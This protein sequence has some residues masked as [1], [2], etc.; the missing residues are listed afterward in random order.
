MQFPKSHPKQVKTNKTSPNNISM[1][2][3]QDTN[4]ISTFLK[5]ALT[6]FK[7]FNQHSLDKTVLSQWNDVKRFAVHNNWFTE[8]VT[9]ENKLGFIKWVKAEN[10]N[11]EFAHAFGVTSMADLLEQPLRELSARISD[12]T[13]PHAS[14]AY[15][16]EYPVDA[17]NLANVQIDV[18]QFWIV[19]D[20]VIENWNQNNKEDPISFRHVLAMALSPTVRKEA[21]PS[22]AGYIVNP[23]GVLC[24]IL[25]TPNLSDQLQNFIRKA[26]FGAVP[27]TPEPA[28]AEQQTEH[29]S[30]HAAQKPT[31]PPGQTTPAFESKKPKIQQSVAAMTSTI[32]AVEPKKAKDRQPVESATPAIPA[33]KPK[34]PEVQLTTQPPQPSIES[35]TLGFRINDYTQQAALKYKYKQ[36]QNIIS[37]YITHLRAVNDNKTS[38]RCKI[39][40]LETLEANLN[41]ARTDVTK[42]AVIQAFLKNSN[43]M[44][45]LTHDVDS[46]KEKLIRA[47]KIVVSFLTAGIAAI[48]FAAH[49]KRYYGTV[50]FGSRHANRG[51]HFAKDSNKFVKSLSS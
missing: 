11:N 27:D 16:N 34:K 17:K 48:G 24:G 37:E 10:S 22:P 23:L 49:S 41:Q 9:V 44:S 32:P 39:D 6:R 40:I 15:A 50:F 5:L 28:L 7:P 42:K 47:C 21:T 46:F 45:T 1:L 25:G 14:N 2:Q 12:D 3:E 43:T 38:A 18:I 19:M 35:N 51:E 26:Y 36:L 8:N 31:T 29:N 13:S 20:K 4:P 30:A 33:A